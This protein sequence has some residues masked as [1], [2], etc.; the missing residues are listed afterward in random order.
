MS[1]FGRRGQANLPVLAVAL[2]LLTTVTAVSVALADGALA[3]AER[4]PGDRRV[5]SAVAERLVAADSPT[6]TRPNVL[7]ASAVAR[8]DAERLDRLAPPTQTASVRVRLGDRTL[9]TRG[10]PSGG[11][12]VRRVVLV[13]ERTATTRTLDL[14]T[15]T[16]L[17][18]PRRTS[19]IT[20]DVDTADTTT[21]RTLRAND[22][23]VLHDEGGLGEPADG[24]TTVRT[25]RYETTTLSFEATESPEGTVTVTFYPTETTKAVLEVTA[26]A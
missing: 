10:T 26:D 1:L 9:V 24:P 21:V 18:V 6:T 20:V 7:N 25:S 22:R 19:R 23:V 17:T 5:A 15:S 16:T 2:I 3:G 12:T 13:A 11:V 8:L 14:T 4:D